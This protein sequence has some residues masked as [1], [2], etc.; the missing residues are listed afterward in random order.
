MANDKE[1]RVHPDE[2]AFEGELV[3]NVPISEGESQEGEQAGEKGGSGGGGFDTG[4]HPY[5]QPTSGGITS[6]TGSGEHGGLTERGHISGADFDEIVNEDHPQ[7]EPTD[8]EREEQ[9]LYE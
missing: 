3:K 6:S 7:H 2:E 8:E 5:A 1:K 4:L 9:R